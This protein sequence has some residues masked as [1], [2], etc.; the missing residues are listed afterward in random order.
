MT[1]LL[2]GSSIATKLFLPGSRLNLVHRQRLL[3]RLDEAL[4]Q[5]IRLAIISAPAGFGKTSLLAEWAAQLFNPPAWVT[6]D[7]GDNDP[8]TFLSYLLAAIQ[9]VKPTLTPTSLALLN[10]QP[11]APPETITAMLVN[12]LSALE[13]E[14]PLVLALDDWQFIHNSTVRDILGFLVDRMPPGVRLAIATRADPLLPLARLRARGQMIELRAADLRFTP[15]EASKFLTFLVRLPIEEKKWSSLFTAL[16]A[17][18]EGW[19]AGLQMAGLALKGVIQQDRTEYGS[20]ND[21][22]TEQEISSFIQSFSGS[23]RFILD[24]LVEE[25][26]ER[27]PAATVNFLLQTSVF[28]RFCAEL[29]DAV[30]DL[31]E[32]NPRITQPG[33][34]LGF[35]RTLILEI[36]Q[37]NLFLIP[38]DNE[39][40]W[41]RYHHL[42]TDLLRARYNQSQIGQAKQLLTRASIWYE[43]EAPSLWQKSTT[44]ENWIAQSIHYALAAEDFSRATSLVEKHTIALLSR[45]ELHNLL[46]WINLLPVEQ[47]TQH[48][49]LCVCRAWAYY[50]SGNMQQV[51]EAIN[52]AR[53]HL[54]VKNDVPPQPE[55]EANIAAINCVKAV[56]LNDVESVKQHAEL[57][58]SLLPASSWAHSVTVWGTAYIS[59]SQG[60]L[61]RASELFARVLSND[62]SRGNAWGVAMSATDL[63]VVYRIQGH[64]RDSLQ[65][66]YSALE[67]IESQQARRN[68]YVGRLLTALAAS[69]YESND[70]D[71]AQTFLQEAVDLNQIWFNPNHSVFA[72]VNLARVLTAKGD[73]QA[74]ASALDS[75][76]SAMRG[77]PIVATLEQSIVSGRIRLMLAQGNIPSIDSPYETDVQDILREIRLPLKTF[78]DAREMRQGSAVRVLILQ[79]R[80]HESLDILEHMEE[81][82]HKYKR[83][84][85]LIEILGLKALALFESGQ[86]KQSGESFARALQLA[87][88]EGYLRAFLD[89]VPLGPVTIRRILD[90]QITSADPSTLSFALDLISALPTASGMAA[91]PKPELNQLPTITSQPQLVEPLTN[92]ELEVLSLIAEGL[93]NAQI[94][95]RLVIS[96]GTVKAHTA[97]IFR[98]LDAANRTQAV[99]IARS[100]GLIKPGKPIP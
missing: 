19:A 54:S 71:Q 64:L 81:A 29:C 80:F 63:G 4:A 87:H 32:S 38:L 97:S 33:S 91:S 9:R 58:Q 92:R 74:A 2:A 79:K 62:L 37:A 70:L 83:N 82:A 57:A 7:E 100:S 27:L 10:A 85:I 25:V 44:K 36:E 22:I 26:L 40:H 56:I 6:V 23:H 46:R 67:F 65:T 95:Q 30:I 96:F 50:F 89:L 5:G 84:G 34:R 51:D 61:E 24:Y 45:G 18:T 59:R 17:R 21:G 72:Y 94:G 35:I 43:T 11:P 52:L 99:A 66:F 13:P 15:D 28:D 42:F 41:F 73:F 77:L 90:D 8:Y 93:S 60:D 69:L 76:E 49:W 75:A 68:G 3:T 39:R 53:L 55:I 88:P 14:H 16:I 20:Q 31:D 47:A 78:H 98:K 12:E 1:N 48:P 86:K